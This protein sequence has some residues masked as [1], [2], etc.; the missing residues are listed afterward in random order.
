MQNRKIY[1]RIY[2]RFTDLYIYKQHIMQS[3]YVCIVLYLRTFCPFGD[4]ICVVV[5]SGTSWPEW[6]GDWNPSAGLENRVRSS[7]IHGAL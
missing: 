3:T 2:A 7:H 1:I 4:S 6:S 5:S